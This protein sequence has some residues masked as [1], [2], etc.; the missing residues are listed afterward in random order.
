MYKCLQ[1]FTFPSA[2]FDLGRDG[3]VCTTHPTT[4]HHITA[5]APMSSP[6]AICAFSFRVAAI[7]AHKSGAPFPNASNVTPASSCVNCSL[8]ASV[9]RSG[10]RNDCERWVASVSRSG[11]RVRE[12]RSG[13]LRGGVCA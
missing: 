3:E 10:V 6:T 8:A 4:A 11:R 9:E 2:K 13:I 12:R 1:C 7:V 5:A